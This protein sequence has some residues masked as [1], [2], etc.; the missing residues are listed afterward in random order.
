VGVTHLSAPEGHQNQQLITVVEEKAIARWCYEQDDR[1]LPPQLDMVKDM[2]LHLESKR[3]AVGSHPL[4][5][6]KNWI[7]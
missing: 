5:L 7:K 1:G 6:G 3:M 2:T 4:P